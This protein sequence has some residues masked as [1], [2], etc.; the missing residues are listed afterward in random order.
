M[1]GCI[2]I[3]ACDNMDISNVTKDLFYSISN[4]CSFKFYINQKTVKKPQKYKS[5]NL[6]TIIIKIILEQHF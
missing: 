1:R 4:K 3:D 5:A 6:S 2:K